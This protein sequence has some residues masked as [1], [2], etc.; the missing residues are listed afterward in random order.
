MDVTATMMA[1]ALE[2]IIMVVVVAEM[3]IVVAEM[4][5]MVVGM[6]TEEAMV[7]AMAMMIEKEAGEVVV[8]A[9]MMGQV[10]NFV[11]QKGEYERF[12]LDTFRMLPADVFWFESINRM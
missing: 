11:L 2:E 7:A 9:M 6:T 5:T 1:M 12:Y 3:V 8:E 4:A 10:G